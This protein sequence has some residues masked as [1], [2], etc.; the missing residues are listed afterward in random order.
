MF[1]KGLPSSNQIC[2]KLCFQLFQDYH[3][4]QRPDLDKSSGKTQLSLKIDAKL[5]REQKVEWFMQQQEKKYKLFS[6]TFDDPWFIQQWYIDRPEGSNEPTFNVISAWEAGYT[7]KGIM[8][9]VVDDGVDGSHPELKE[10]YN[11]TLSYDYVANKHMEYGTEVSGHGNKCAGVIAGTRNNDLCGTGL[12]YEANIAGVRL[13]DNH[14]W[15]N[16][17]SESK[18]LVHKL[19]SVDIYSNSWGPGDV[20]WEVKGP[21]PLTSKALEIGTSKGRGGL[22]AIYTFSAGNGGL[23]G[24][25]CA[26]NGY[27]NSIYT[28]AI[29]G[30]NQDNSLPSYAEECPGIMASAYSR[31]SYRNFGKVVTVDNKKGCVHNFSDSSAA[32]AMATGLIALTL[33]ANP[34]LTWRDVQHIIARSARAEPGGVKLKEGDWKQNKAGLFFSKYYGFGLMDAGEMVNLAKRWTKVPQHLKCEFGGS[35]KTEKIPSTVSLEVKNC[36]IKFLEHVQIRVNLDFSRRGDLLL[37]LKSPSNTTCPLTRDRFVD[38]YQKF[39]N[40]TDWHIT[41]LFHWGEKANGRWELKISD[42]H[43]RNPSTGKLHRWSLILY[44]T[45]SD[46][47]KP[48]I[49]DYITR[50]PTIS[51]VRPTR[52]VTMKTFA[53]TSEPTKSVPVRMIVVTV[54]SVVIVFACVS[55]AIAYY[56]FLKKRTPVQDENLREQRKASHKE[57]DYKS[58]MGPHKKPQGDMV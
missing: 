57:I 46:P 10:N 32:A 55:S 49:K 30:V 42:A 21:G 11:W 7:G 28:I 22:G 50:K 8:V 33:Q 15:S 24:D 6:K 16:D 14:I 27:V 12:A 34:K 31:D 40:L 45:S 36:E 19:Q 20:G 48:S 25:S 43:T 35:Y 4:F 9:A 53:P 44:G 17:A 41:T 38:N 2:K 3:L 54:S 47:L 13:F 23:D 52:T 29:N 39:T 18:A 58:S 37:H 5:S 56:Y 51:P 26:Y 1:H